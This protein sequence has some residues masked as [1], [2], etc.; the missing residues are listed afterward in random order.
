MLLSNDKSPV[1]ATLYTC[2]TTLMLPVCMQT[3]K[4]HAQGFGLIELLT[5]IDIGSNNVPA[6]GL[7]L[8]LASEV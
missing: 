1:L 6:A 3:Q 4:I 7:A 2:Y 5:P 8:M